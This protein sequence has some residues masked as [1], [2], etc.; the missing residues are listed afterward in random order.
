MADL[1][2]LLEQRKAQKAK[3]P[4]FKRQ[5]WHKK[6][7]LQPKWRKP[8]GM[9]SKLRKHM[10]GH[11][12]L[13][14]TGYRSPAAVRGMH[15]SGVVQ[16]LIHTISQLETINGKTHG[17][18]IASSVGNRNRLEMFTKAHAKG[19]RVLNFKNPAEHAKNVKDAMAAHK[20]VRAKSKAPVTPTKPAK[21]AP[22]A[23]DSQEKKEQERR[24]A[25]K[26]ITSKQ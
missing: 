21:A 12:H 1:K 2:R 15:K 6:A 8:K 18:I 11:G 3:K 4:H 17:V 26:V 13:P 7:R 24:D 25:E 19:I 10:H 20:A 5:D 16:V 23:E 9:D 14:T 22:K